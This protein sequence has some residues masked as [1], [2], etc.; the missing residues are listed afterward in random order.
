MKLIKKMATDK[1]YLKIGTLRNV[2]HDLPCYEFCCDVSVTEPVSITQAKM[3]RLI[4]CDFPHHISR[5]PNGLNTSPEKGRD[6]TQQH[7]THVV[8]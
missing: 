8:K 4:F 6:E 7:E 3:C 2:N 5:L 1:F